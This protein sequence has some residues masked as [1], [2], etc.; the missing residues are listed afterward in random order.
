MNTTNIATGSIFKDTSKEKDFNFINKE[1][2][3]ITEGKYTDI[4]SQR[5]WNKEAKKENVNLEDVIPIQETVGKEV[6]EDYIN[7]KSTNDEP[8]KLAKKDDRYYIINGTHRLALK[9]LNKEKSGRFYVVDLKE[10]KDKKDIKKSEEDK[11]R[12]GKADN[13]TVDQIAE[14]HGVSVKKIL[15]QLKKGVKVEMEHTDNKQVALEIARDH[16][17]EFVDYYTRL[18]KMEN[19]AKKENKDNEK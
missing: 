4:T 16:V 12:G 19:E 15:K 3:D 6:L 1:L 10:L 11:I 9:I 2:K 18:E 7:G 8:V 17:E 5:V 14:K 13:L